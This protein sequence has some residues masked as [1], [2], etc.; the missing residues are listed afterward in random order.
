M[1]V[2]IPLG[3]EAR[4]PERVLTNDVREVRPD[5]AYLRTILV[6]VAFVGLP[7]AGDRAWVL[8]D[9]G[10]IG[11]KGQ[12]KEA[13]AARFG[14]GAR[15]A[16]ILQTHGHFDHIGA[17]QD[18]AAEWDAPVFAHPL[19]APFLTG[20]ESYP[21]PDTSADGGIMP[22]L[23]PLFP[24]APV[25]VSRHLRLLP[26]D[27]SVPPLPGWRWL[28]TPGHTPGHV[29]LF[30]DEDRTLIAGDAVISTGQESAYE[31]AVQTLEMHGPPRYFTPDWTAARDSVRKIAALRPELIVTGHGRALAGAAMR[32]ALDQLA[33]RFDAIA[34]PEARRTAL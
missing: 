4:A 34:P 18:L 19:E 15:P 11:T 28:H 2:Q 3:E 31:V 32:E 22:K 14:E 21:P 20:R 13:A 25:D 23:A 24:R 6:N 9:C 29:S 17:L 26:D 27:G 7:E 30:R 5:L 8:I 12:I 33:D 10:I 16:A 1:A